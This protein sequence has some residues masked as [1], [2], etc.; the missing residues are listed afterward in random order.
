V[1][2]GSGEWGAQRVTPIARGCRWSY[3]L[4]AHS[5]NLRLL[6]TKPM[7]IAV[8]AGGAGGVCAALAMATAG[9]PR[10]ACAWTA[11]A[12]VIASLAYLANRPAWLGKRGG[13]LRL[14]ALA[15]LP[16]LVAFHVACVLMRWWRGEDRP[17]QVAPDLWVAG[18]L[19]SADL[20]PGVTYV[21]DLTAEFSE[22]AAI[23]RLPGYRSLPVLDGGFPAAEETFL[24]LV[25]EL[26]EADG[27]VLVHCDA[28][29]GRA[30]TF[31][32][33]LCIARG[34]VLEV[35]EAI[36]LVRMR[37]KVSTPTGSDL[38]F[39]AA[40][41]P[42]LRAIAAARAQACLSPRVVCTK[43]LLGEHQ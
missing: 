37:R 7:K 40:V 2:I 27:G 38:A 23:R 22:V 4:P 11:F 39:L 10:L 34:F 17:S 42:K 16:Y 30:P 18:R 41:C 31:A 14:P 8:G 1:E 12:C 13:R 26:V 33:A 36:A 25:C 19:R 29:R 15:V 3:R 32:A 9:F 35:E 43:M 28:G 5:S 6:V 24:T 20:P 21:V